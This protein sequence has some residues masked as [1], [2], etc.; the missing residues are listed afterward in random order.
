VS[1]IAEEHLAL[2]YFQEKW[3][4][5]TVVRPSK[6]YGPGQVGEGALKT[7]ILRALENAPIEIHEDGTQIRARLVSLSTAD[8]ELRS[9]SV[10]KAQNLLNFGATINLEEGLSRTAESYRDHQ[11]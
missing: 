10:E 3:L 4:P 7:F 2:A 8:V 11:E 6:V 1:K 9:P 5:A